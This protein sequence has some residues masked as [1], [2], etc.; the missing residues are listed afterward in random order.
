MQTH[1]QKLAN[2]DEATARLPWFSKNNAD[3]WI[4]CEPPPFDHQTFN[5]MLENEPVP[6]TT[7]A[8]LKTHHFLR[9]AKGI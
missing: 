8:E 7:S 1:N 4:V 6:E 5:E 2:M 9:Q 3:N